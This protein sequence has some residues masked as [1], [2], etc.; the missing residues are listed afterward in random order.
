[1]AKQL[2]VFLCIVSLASCA[3]APFPNERLY[4]PDL[5]NGICAE[6]EIVNL[7]E[8]TFR[9]VKD[10]P[11]QVRGPCDRMAGFKSSGFKRVQNWIRDEIKR[12]KK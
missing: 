12:N 2:G 5:A 8:I 9:H 6:Y 4:I 1:M 11:L 10:W 7:E 3:I